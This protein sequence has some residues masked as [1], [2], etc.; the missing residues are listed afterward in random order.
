MHIHHKYI[1]EG[2]ILEVGGIDYNERIRFKTILDESKTNKDLLTFGLFDKLQ[3]ELFKQ[4]YHNIFMPFKSSHLFQSLTKSVKQKYNNVRIEDFVYYQKLGEGGFG[5]VVHCMKKSTGKHFAMKIQTK[6][7]LLDCF[8]DDP[9]R[10]DYE[11][12]ALASCQHPFIINMDYSFQTKSLAIMVLGLATA[13]DLQKALLHCPEERLSADRVRFYMA[14]VVL[15]LGYLHQKG[16]MYR[17]LK[18][19]NILL[20]SNGHIQ[21]VDLGGVVDQDGNLLDGKKDMMHDF[22]PMLYRPSAGSLENESLGDSL[23]NIDGLNLKPKR[24]MSIMGT[25][26]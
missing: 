12:N 13:G 9:S 15:A 16:F 19:N 10:V 24:R 23:S 8:N 3:H 4:M 21:L 20:N 6:K 17:D 5:L 1:K 7:G 2:S 25:F 22:S 14:E 11:K 18:P 26:G